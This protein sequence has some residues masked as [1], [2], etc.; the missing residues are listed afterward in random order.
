M[1]GASKMKRVLKEFLSFALVLALEVLALFWVVNFFFHICADALTLTDAQRQEV[2]S[3]VMAEAG[4]ESQ[5]AQRMIA[6]CILNGCEKENVEPDELIEL[7]RYTKRR[8]EPSESVQEAVQAVFDEGVKDYG[9]IL[10]FYAPGLCVSDWHES[11]EFVTEI[12]GI[13]FFGE[14]GT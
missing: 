7:Y 11:Q 13:R 4:G 10:Y 6:L 9:N 8:P 5:E 14:A 12:D 2:E 1:K 3:V